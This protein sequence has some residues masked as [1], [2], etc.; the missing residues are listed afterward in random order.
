MRPELL[1]T[2]GGVPK[3]IVLHLSPPIDRSW[4]VL[5]SSCQYIILSSTNVIKHTHIS[6]LSIICTRKT[7]SF[8]V[9]I[10]QT[11]Q[12]FQ[13]QVLLYLHNWPP[14]RLRSEKHCIWHLCAYYWQNMGSGTFVS[15]SHRNLLRLVLVIKTKKGA[16]A[17]S[18]IKAKKI[19][20][21]PPPIF[22]DEMKKL[23]YE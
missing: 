6:T 9:Y 23:E 17:C 15:A 5:S 1:I 13:K 3:D 20:L 11:N 22:A 7:S 18:W 21:L 14:R 10:S 16:D 4:G 8:W 12:S 2:H 19:P